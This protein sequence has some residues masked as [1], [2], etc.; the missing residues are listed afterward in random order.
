MAKAIAL[1][2]GIEDDEFSESCVKGCGYALGF[3]ATLVLAALLTL[4]AFQHFQKGNVASGLEK[5][6]V[7]VCL[8]CQDICNKVGYPIYTGVCEVSEG[9]PKCECVMPPFL[10]T[11][12]EIRPISYEVL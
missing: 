9:F 1:E 12:S 6:D 2:K 8:A 7:G 11:P 5:D 3:L 10:N 4:A